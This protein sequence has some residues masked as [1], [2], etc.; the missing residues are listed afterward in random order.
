[1]PTELLHTDTTEALS[2]E[3]RDCEAWAELFNRRHR[4]RKERTATEKKLDFVLRAKIT[5]AVTQQ[6][7]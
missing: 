1:M 4:P 5:T 7:Q 3:E 6:E 2:Q